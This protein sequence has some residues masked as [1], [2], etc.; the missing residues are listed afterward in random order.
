MLYTTVKY[1]LAVSK[2]SRIEE[3]ALIQALYLDLNDHLAPTFP[4][5]GRVRKNST[6]TTTT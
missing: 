6:G 1:P 2:I 3:F 5:G 4:E